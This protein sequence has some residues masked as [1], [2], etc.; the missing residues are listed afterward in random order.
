MEA[1]TMGS[2]N[3]ASGMDPASW[4][5]LTRTLRDKRYSKVLYEDDE[6]KQKSEDQLSEPQ[7]LIEAYAPAFHLFNQ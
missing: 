7:E 3:A 5:K 2:G 4:S 1:L 6:L